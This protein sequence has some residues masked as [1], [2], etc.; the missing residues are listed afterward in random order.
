MGS[1]LCFTAVPIIGSFIIDPVLRKDERGHFSRAWCL[2]E[3]AEQGIDFI[4]VQA[5]TGYSLHK[6]T[7]R[8]MHYQVAP[9]PEAKLVRC[10]KGSLYDVIV[11]LRPNSAT[12][13]KWFGIKLCADQYRLL[14]IPV[15]CA[16]GYQTLE[17]DTD[18]YYM[19]SQYF[20]PSA[21]RGV[22]YNDPVL[23]IQWPLVPTV[24]SEQ[25]RNWPMIDE[26]ESL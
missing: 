9:A 22:R 21:A 2:K 11:D 24:M 25:D 26:R 1:S 10:T 16:H 17:D 5:N 18:L 20:T 14:Y 4:P 8:G 7:L 15:G 13:H 6:G 12:R 3:F 23:N 19:T